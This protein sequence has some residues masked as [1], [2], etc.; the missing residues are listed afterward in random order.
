M[1]FDE[2]YWEIEE[3]KK[4]ARQVNKKIKGKRTDNKEMKKGEGS[5][6]TACPPCSVNRGGGLLA[7]VAYGWSVTEKG[8]CDE[9]RWQSAFQRNRQGCGGKGSKVVDAWLQLE[10]KVGGGTGNS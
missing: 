3:E 4:N 7:G 10:R 5:G 8:R 2:L 6:A 1:S 9:R